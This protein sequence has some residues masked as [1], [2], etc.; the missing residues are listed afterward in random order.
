M[1]SNTPQSNPLSEMT[2]TSTRRGVLAAIATSVTAGCANLDVLG[3]PAPNIS[4]GPAAVT[5]SMYGYDA[6]KTSHVPPRELPATDAEPHRF[7]Q[8]GSNRNS[9]GSIEAPPV[10][11]DDVVYVAGDVR[12]EAREIDSGDRLWETDPEDSVST[13]PVV[14][15]GTLYVSTANETLALDIEDGSEL[16]RADVDAHFGAS[17]SPVVH[18][19]TIYVAGQGVTALDAETG[20]ERWHRPTEYGDHGIAVDERVYVGT[21]SNGTGEVVAI[22]RDGEYWW[23]SAEAGQ[24]YTAPVAANDLVYAV[25]KTGTVTALTAEGGTVEWQANVEPGVYEPPA[26]A[27]GRVIVPAGNG[28]R[29]IALDARTGD[30]LWTFETGV[31]QGAPVVLGEQVLTS[32]ANTGF[33]L[34]DAETGDRV[35]HWPVDNVGSQPVVADGKLFYRGWDVSDAFVIHEAG[36]SA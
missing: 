5:W 23:R 31:S 14:A 9:G 16:W 36:K 28:T 7:T 34:L 15:C 17:T 35:R 26:V 25:S 33:Y 1:N 13:G 4:C 3:S 6:A 19:D 18:D 29:T 10:V 21:G 20:D 12:I 27:D 11:A 8:T 24:V 32:G 22:T 2:A 30:R